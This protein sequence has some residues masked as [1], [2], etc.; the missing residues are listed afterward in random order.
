MF[1]VLLALFAPTVASAEK[2]L[3]R[4]QRA[5]HVSPDG[6]I[7]PQTRRA[8]KRFQRSHH[9]APVD[10]RL[11]ANV[12]EA[13][14]EGTRSSAPAPAP[15]T[16]AV[17]AA[18]SVIGSPY[19]SAGTTPSGFDCSGLTMWAFKQAGVKLP[20]SSYDQY[21]MG[22]AVADADI[23]VGDLVF[24]NTAGSGASHVGIATD[25][26]HAISATSHGV[27]EHSFATG[28]WSDHFLGAR[29]L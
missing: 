8:V 26:T 3:A 15:T 4:A 7:G 16:D 14:A 19:A 11:H 10:G 18:R 23:R 1:A 24:F 20:H 21:T 28:Y 13:L 25:A 17:T 2:P 5:L 22:T 27:M 29:R 6:H 9:L 12:L